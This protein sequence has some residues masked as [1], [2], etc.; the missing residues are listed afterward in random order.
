MQQIVLQVRDEQKA[1]MLRDLLASLDFV[2][3]I[4]A[5]EIPERKTPDNG[6]SHPFALDRHPQR[7]QMERE[8]AAFEAM[9]E[10]LKEHY[11]DQFVAIHQGRVMDSDRDEQSLLLRVRKNLANDVVLF[12]KV[13]ETLP[14]VLVLRSPRFA[15]D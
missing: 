11:L 14:P 5:T 8:V 15:E 7:E 10:K 12:R 9:H 3:A 4:S 13:Q 2:E 6:D 1:E